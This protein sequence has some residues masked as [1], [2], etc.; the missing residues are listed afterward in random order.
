[1]ERLGVGFPLYS[2]LEYL[3]AAREI[4]ER[5][6]DYYEI[7]PEA[8]WRMEDGRLGRNGYYP[9]L[10]KIRDR[11]GK[12][13]VAHGLAFSP[14]TPL[15]DEGEGGRAETWLARLR[16]D[17][18]QFRFEWMTEHLGWITAGGLQTVLPMPLPMTEEAVGVVA[19]RLRMLASVTPVVAFENSA[20]PFVLGDAAREPDFFNSICRA[21][22]CAMLLDL[23]NVHAQCRNFGV[24]PFDYVGRIEL[25]R[26]VQ[27]HLSGG[28]ESDPEWLPSKRVFRLDSHDGP[29]PDAVWSL[30]ERVRPGCRNLRGVVVERLNGTFGAEDVPALREELRRAREVFVSC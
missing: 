16:D 8:L 12:R 27:I 9:I 18:A 4:I 28:S 19:G 21:A 14:G 26:V 29:I 17:Q 11:S 10:Q 7:N 5:D 3:M 24:D 13:F 25:E 20:T 23:H 22:D 6:A 1:M 30:Y 15:G 2:D